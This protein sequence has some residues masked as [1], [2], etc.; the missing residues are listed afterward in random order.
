[1]AELIGQP[2]AALSYF[3]GYLTLDP[4]R[5]KQRSCMPPSDSSSAISAA[6]RMTIL[7][8]EPFEH[9]PFRRWDADD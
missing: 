8:H 6:D 3:D 5:T 4:R 7:Y 2:D 1:V 9:K